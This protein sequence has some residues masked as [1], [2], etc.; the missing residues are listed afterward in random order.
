M[1]SI[2]D[3]IL[4]HL[5]TTLPLFYFNVMRVFA[6]SLTYAFND[7]LYVGYN[8]Y[9]TCLYDS[10]GFKHTDTYIDMKMKLKY[11]S[12]CAHIIR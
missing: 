5:R 7:H 4:F 2:S 8:K 12:S 11:E 10:G 3:D 6:L 9:I 1:Q